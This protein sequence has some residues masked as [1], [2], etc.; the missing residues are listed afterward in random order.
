MARQVGCVAHIKEAG[1]TCVHCFLF[2]IH[3]EYLSP[4]PFGRAS[5]A[6]WHQGYEKLT[7]MIVPRSSQMVSQDPD[8]GLFT[9]TLFK[10][11]VD[12]FKLHARERK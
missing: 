12:E 8:Y 11:V 4:V 1:D 6:D 7:D 10:K 5:F 3:F 9:V 2:I